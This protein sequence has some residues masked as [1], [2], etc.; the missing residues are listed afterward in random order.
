M[1]AFFGQVDDHIKAYE[2]GTVTISDDIEFSMR[3]TVR[4][5][6]HYIL[7]RY[8]DGGKDNKD[9][10]TGKRRP[11]RNIGNAI[12]DIEWRAKNI[13]R[14]SIEGHAT[15][16]DFLFSLIVNK[17]LQLWMKNNNFGKTIDDYQRKKSEYG[18]V[19]LKKT[20]R[21]GE[22]IIEPVQWENTYVDPNDIA[23]GMKVEKGT[24]SLL[25]LKKRAEVWDE[26]NDEGESN[27]ELAIKEAK[28][29]KER[30]VEILDI[31]GE[32][33]YCD[34]YPDENEEDPDDEIGLYNVIVAQVGKKKFT[35]YKT[36][37]KD[38]RFK[39]DRRKDVESR[40]WG[41]GVW[42]ECFEPQ[43]STNEM[44]IA[45]RDVMDIAGKVLVKTNKKNQRSVMELASGETIDMA[46]GEFFDAVQLTPTSLPKFQQIIDAW[47]LNM[48][49]D[50]S[51]FPAVTGEES[52]AGTPFAADALHAAQA[53]SIFN[54]RRDQDS[55]FLLEVLM[56]WV[57][58]FVVHQVNKDHTLDASYSPKELELIDEAIRNFHK[59]KVSK[60]ALLSDEFMEPGMPF[61]TLP[62]DREMIGTAVQQQLE[63]Q[64]ANR[65]L[66]IPKGFITLAKIKQKMRFDI[67]DEMSDDQRRL[68]ALATALGQLAPADPARG[69]IVQ[70]M[71]EITGISAASFP[72]IGQGTAA[73]PAKTKAPSRVEEVLPKGQQV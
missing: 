34:I 27:L 17:E 33:E 8:M 28:K 49:R 45:E 9:P 70:E 58:P 41:M 10:L 36:E 69:P 50:Q 18:N 30:D 29:R 71:M 5:I 21:D 37:L 65:T 19:L 15:D 23:G 16:G 66:K 57:L 48:Q 2:T 43:I 25:E 26:Q 20:E 53:G 56:D 62:E 55:Y 61:G 38:T 35:L 32:F 7:S 67:T 13:D 64:G 24:L 1:K 11:F 72:V 40:D 59:D 47:F 14:K 42:E 63:K 3:R 6:T 46:D 4:Q 60:D 31:E 68:N 54:K 22:L 39:F 44:V 73:T 12:V 52:K 51:A